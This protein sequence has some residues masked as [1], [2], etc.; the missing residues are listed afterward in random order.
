MHR[1][2]GFSFNGAA[3]DYFGIWIVNALIAKPE[4]RSGREKQKKASP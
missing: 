3:R 4:T 1:Q 2:M